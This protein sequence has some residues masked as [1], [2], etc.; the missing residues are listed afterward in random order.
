MAEGPKIEVIG[1]DE[2]GIFIYFIYLNEVK[3]SRI[4][5]I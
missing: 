1:A 2:I 4:L 3:K 5:K